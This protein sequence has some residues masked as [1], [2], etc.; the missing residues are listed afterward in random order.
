MTPVHLPIPSARTERPAIDPEHH[1]ADL[2]DVTVAVVTFQGERW[3]RSCLLAVLAQTHRATQ[4]EVIDN[5]STDRT[6]EVA[7]AV[8]RGVRGARITVLPRNVG[9]AAGHNLGIRAAQ[10]SAI[11]LLNQDVVLEPTYLEVAVGVLG[12]QPDVGAVQGLLLGIGPDGEQLDTV[13]ST[14]LVLARDRRILSRDQGRP[15]SLAVMRPGRVFGPDGPAPVYRMRALAGA[16]Y[17]PGS[18]ASE[19]LDERFFLYHEDT[20]LAWRL[21]RLR[22]HTWYAPDAVAWHARGSP[23]PSSTSIAS[24]V[25]RSRG[26][27]SLARGLAW[28]NGR[29]SIIKNDRP[30]AWIAAL[31]AI[32]RREMGSAALMFATAPT[33]LSWAFSLLRCLPGTLRRRAA[34]RAAL[35]DPRRVGPCRDIAC[36]WHPPVR[37]LGP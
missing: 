21:A 19:V 27:S 33:R 24:L 7:H 26:S 18:G 1:P 36:P 8:L 23:G 11:C 35:L 22:W 34:I 13:D 37:R 31:P 6:V 4:I 12:E 10:S 20:D 3:I 9:Y 32:A 16:A 28:R 2:P 5:A 30:D 17:E 15:R 25:R 14:G 29:L